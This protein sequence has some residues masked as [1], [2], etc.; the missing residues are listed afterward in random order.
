MPKDRL[1]RLIGDPVDIEHLAPERVRWTV[2]L[3]A[4]RRSLLLVEVLSVSLLMFGRRLVRGVCGEL[5]AHN[6]PSPEEHFVRR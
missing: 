3:K 4:M 1:G 5:E 2:A 6:L